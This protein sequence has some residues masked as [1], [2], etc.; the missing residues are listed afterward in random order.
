[1]TLQHNTWEHDGANSRESISSPLALIMESR[2]LWQVGT[3]TVN[4]HE[5]G[6]SEQAMASRSLSVQTSRK[7]LHWV[8]PFHSQGT[9]MGTHANLKSTDS[10]LLAHST[11]QEVNLVLWGCFGC[12]TVIGNEVNVLRS[13]RAG[14]REVLEDGGEEK[15]QFIAGNAF[16]K[17]NALSC[18]EGHESFI[19]LQCPIGIQEVLRIEAVWL[20]KVPW[21]M[22]S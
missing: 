17:T 3:M 21:V 1:M 14:Q 12:T 19:C 16:S 10:P 18:G 20:F 2:L 5:R 8:F 22:K 11:G 4:K 15:E 13:Y 6:D 7:V 9:E